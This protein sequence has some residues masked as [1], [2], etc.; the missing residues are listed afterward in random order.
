MFTFSVDF[1]KSGIYKITNNVTDM[2]YIGSSV[3]M[4]KR[5]TEHFCRLRSKTHPN[6]HL[7]NAYTKYG[8]ENFAVSI[9]ELAKENT[10]KQRE[11]VW[12]D[13]TGVANRDIGYNIAPSVLDRSEC[14]EETRQNISALSSGRIVTTEENRKRSESLKRYYLYNSHN[15]GRKHTPETIA[16]MRIAQKGRIITEEAKQKMSKAHTGKTL[17]DEHKKK[18]RLSV[19]KT[20]CRQKLDRQKEVGQL[21]LEGLELE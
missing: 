9:L 10:L 7:Q 1:R 16:R 13:I 5:L 15:I 4:A 20:K 19:A 12:L 2:F 11:Q 17:S 14:A 18:I 21:F 8:E 3:N 6:A